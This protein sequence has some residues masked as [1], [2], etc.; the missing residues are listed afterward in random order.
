M[1]MRGEEILSGAQRIHDPEFLTKR[2]LE[3][4]CGKCHQTKRRFALSFFQ[5]LSWG[6]VGAGEAAK[7][8]VL[9]L[10]GVI[11]SNGC[12]GG[13]ALLLFMCHLFLKR[14]Y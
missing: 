10:L 14:M 4:G 2:A 3:H 5:P 8:P 13:G 12:I 11:F 1:F 6:R 9:L 7:D